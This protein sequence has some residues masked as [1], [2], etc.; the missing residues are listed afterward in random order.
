MYQLHIIA[1]ARHSWRKTAARFREFSLPN[2]NGDIGWYW[3]ILGATAPK[4]TQAAYFKV[5]SKS[6]SPA[7][8]L[9]FIGCEFEKRFHK[10]EAKTIWMARTVKH[11][12]SEQCI[13]DNVR[14]LALGT[15]SNFT[16]AQSQ[17]INH[18]SNSVFY[19]KYCINHIHSW[20]NIFKE[21]NENRRVTWYHL[22]CQTFKSVRENTIHRSDIHQ[23]KK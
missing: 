2:I 12:N 9:T 3:V 14:N 7:E 18:I 17:P 1:W 23:K 19:I 16:Q 15:R 4:S 6:I 20:N 22:F 5:K 8:E 10:N 11:W 13:A 21:W